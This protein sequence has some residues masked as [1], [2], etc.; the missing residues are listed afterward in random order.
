[1]FMRKLLFRSLLVAG[2]AAPGVPASAAPI[3]FDFTAVITSVDAALASAFTSGQLVS[4]SYSFESTSSGSSIAFG[5][6]YPLTS[7]AGIAGSYAFSVTGSTCICVRDNWSGPD[8]WYAVGGS[9]SGSSIGSYGPLFQE[10]HLMD[11]GGGMLASDDLPLT[12]PVIPTGAGDL[13][14]M[15][16]GFRDPGA[17]QSAYMQADLTSLTFEGDVETIPEPGTIFLLGCGL[18][19]LLCRRRP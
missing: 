19:A 14:F 17:G 5:L 11:S 9:M 15:R 6:G 16:F 2:L 18:A 12:P 1:M 4:G 7:F 3:T 10:I 8:D 13:A